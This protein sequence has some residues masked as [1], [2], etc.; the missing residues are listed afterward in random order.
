MIANDVMTS[1]AVCVTEDTSIEDLSRVLIRMKISG[2]PVVNENDEIVGMVSEADLLHHEHAGVNAPPRRGRW[3]EMLLSPSERASEFVK[4]HGRTVSDVMTR[5]SVTVASDTPLPEIAT[6]ME[7]NRI[8][9]V[10]VVEDGK[11]VGIVTRRNLIREMAARSV[12]VLINDTDVALRTRV[13]DAIG[14]S[15]VKAPYLS[16]TVDHGQVALDGLTESS[17]ER[18]AL[19]LAVKAVPG[20]KAVENNMQLP[21]AIPVTYI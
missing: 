21:A 14:E 13:Q 6:I 3:A 10:P 18:D 20:V 5:N 1:P 16:V 11:V 2:A 7:K 19:L 9:R 4:M 15:G 17:I 8:K 12:R